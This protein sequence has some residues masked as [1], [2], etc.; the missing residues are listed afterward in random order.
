MPYEHGMKVREN[1]TSLATPVNSTAGLQ[2]VFGTAPINLLANPE[3]AVNKLIICYTM[4]DAIALLGYKDDY[5]KYTLCQSMDAN[6]KLYAVA[7]VVFCNVLDPSKHKTA[8]EETECAIVKGQSTLAVDGILLDSLIVKAGDTPLTKTTHYIATFDDNGNAVITLTSA[9]MTAAS[10]ETAL[11]ISGNKIDP[12]K[13][14]ATDVIGGYDATTGKESGLELI[15]R[16][17]PTFDLAAG[18]I[19]APGWSHI[20]EVGAVMQAKCDSINGSF[21][22]ECIIDISTT[23][24]PKLTDVPAAK[25]NS[26][27][28]SSHAIGVYP[29]VKTA[30]GKIMYYSAVLG[31]LYCSYDASNGNV[32]YRK[33]SNLPMN[34]AGACLADGTEVT[35]DQ[36]EANQLNAIGVVT[37]IKMNG[38]R[39]WGNNTCAYP[40]TQDPKERWIRTRRM[41]SWLGNTFI[42][43]FFEKVDDPTDYRLVESVVDDWNVFCSTLASNSNLA[44]SRMEYIADENPIEQILSGK[45]IFHQYLAVHT[46]AESIENILEF[47]PTMLESVLNG[48]DEE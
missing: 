18:L 45:I 29:M 20:A 6:Y 23:A 32:P 9:G 41:F 42:K 27:L 25:S 30:S 36:L 47:D 37:I 7:P 15:K 38:F 44:D 13:V 33:V 17:F 16:V 4:A 34:I 1:P 46:P 35:L 12:S 21:K 22:C 24:A 48:G 8:V 10:S 26:A 2:I 11:T 43:T 5:S 14:T 40:T 39:A 28:M 31:A 3:S 19:L